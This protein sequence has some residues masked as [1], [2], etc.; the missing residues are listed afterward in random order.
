MAEV[1]HKL[2]PEVEA[3]YYSSLAS[4]DELPYGE[5]ALVV[6]NWTK[7][8]L[9]KWAASK[10]PI[11]SPEFPDHFQLLCLDFARQVLQLPDHFAEFIDNH[12]CG[13]CPK[14]IIRGVKPPEATS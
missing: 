11:S 9:S 1:M 3:V 7:Y 10:A 4:L 5:Q 12:G 8:V 2:N 13:R 6:M 14:C